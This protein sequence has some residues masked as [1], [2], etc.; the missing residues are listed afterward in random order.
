MEDKKYESIYSPISNF[1]DDSSYEA[2]I[3]DELVDDSLI[4]NDALVD[5]N[6]IEE[7]NGIYDD[8]DELEE[9]DEYDEGFNDGWDSA[10]DHAL[11]AIEV[12]RYE[13]Y[14]DVKNLF[15]Q[16]SLLEESHL[17]RKKEAEFDVQGAIK[18]FIDTKWST[19]DEARGKVSNLLKGLLFSDDPKAKKFVKDLDNASDKLNVKDYE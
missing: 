8:E 9:Y 17:I 14:E 4:D 3:N 13:I 7:Y 18:S 12:S 2:P 1:V 15:N 11:K 10:M 16:N 6:D 19:D 5:F